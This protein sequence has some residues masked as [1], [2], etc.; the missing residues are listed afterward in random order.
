MA[1]STMTENDVTFI[2]NM[3]VHEI[4]NKTCVPMEELTLY[5]V[6]NEI[7]LKYAGGKV[8]CEGIYGV[9]EYLSDYQHRFAMK[10]NSNNLFKR[11]VYMSTQ[12]KNAMMCFKDAS[13]NFYQYDYDLT[14]IITFVM[15][16]AV[17]Y[18]PNA[19]VYVPTTFGEPS[20]LPG[21]IFAIQPHDDDDED[22]DVVFSCPQSPHNTYFPDTP[23]HNFIPD[24]S[25]ADYFE[26]DQDEDDDVLLTPH[27]VNAWMS[28]SRAFPV[29]PSI[30]RLYPSALE[31][32]Y[33]SMTGISFCP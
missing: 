11:A 3:L 8:F 26:R 25:I 32:S 9:L 22:Y 5:T 18:V 31:A 6:C 27:A 17:S 28:D 20:N 30:V 33:P 7:L 4:Q 12:F 16:Y 23:T 29:T 14:E 2:E 21:S 13:G 19:D 24:L 15:S 1:S 10:C